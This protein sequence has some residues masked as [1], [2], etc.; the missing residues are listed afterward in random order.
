MEARYELCSSSFLCFTVS[1]F[2]LQIKIFLFIQTNFWLMLE[3]L[4]TWKAAI[5][6]HVWISSGS[7][8]I[9]WELSN[10]M[11][12]VGAKNCRK[13]YISQSLQ[14]QQ[15]LGKE[16]EVP[17]G[18]FYILEGGSIMF[19]WFSEWALINFFPNP[20]GTWN[21]FKR[22]KGRFS[23]MH[24]IS[25]CFILEDFGDIQN[26]QTSQELRNTFSYLG[27]RGMGPHWRHLGICLPLVSHSIWKD[28]IL[29]HLFAKPTRAPSEVEET[30][31]DLCSWLSTTSVL[32]DNLVWY[33]E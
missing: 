27:F 30:V 2:F 25:P 12:S 15:L 17:G 4:R 1:S 22:Q 10:Y 5:I 11:F 29:L 31:G 3:T 6:S 28:T 18:K 14:I 33:L 21:A 32:R 9:S 23:N 19:Q 20:N 8:E 26:F 24:L 7:F 16:N 13:G